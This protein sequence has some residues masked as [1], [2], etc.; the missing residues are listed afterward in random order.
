MP[1]DC[2]CHLVIS[3]NAQAYF[4]LLLAEELLVTRPRHENTKCLLWKIIGCP[5]SSLSVFFLF[6]NL[7]PLF[8]ATVLMRYSKMK[9]SGTD[10]L[11]FILNFSIWFSCKPD[12]NSTDYLWGDTTKMP[13][14]NS[15][16]FPA[17]DN[18]MQALPYD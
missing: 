13:F 17:A 8:N 1:S 7:W 3:H 10:G 18:L 11:R 2:S 4:F 6:F 9:A 5:F 15:H 16:Q 12:F 14:K